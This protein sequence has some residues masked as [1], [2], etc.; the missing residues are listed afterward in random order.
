MCRRAG[1][2]GGGAVVRSGRRN[3]RAMCL[4]PE[5]RRE[6]GAR[7]LKCSWKEL[8]TLQVKGM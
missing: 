8:L 1:E 3:R 4:K 5:G 2:G 7:S 6:K